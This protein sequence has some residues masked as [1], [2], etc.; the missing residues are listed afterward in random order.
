[1]WAEQSYLAHSANNIVVH[2]MYDLHN[3]VLKQFFYVRSKSRNSA[4]HL[5]YSYVY[6]TPCRMRIATDPVTAFT[7][8]TS[9]SLG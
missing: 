9:Y 4:A 5:L 6:R 7:Q 1:M 3:F 2:E 8:S